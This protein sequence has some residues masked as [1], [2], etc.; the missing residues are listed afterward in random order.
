MTRLKLVERLVFATSILALAIPIGCGSGQLE[1]VY[2]KGVVTLDESPVGGAS[3]MFSPTVG[4]PAVGV[5][6][7]EGEFELRTINPGD[8]AVPGA[9]TVIVTLIETTGVTADADGLSGEVAAGGV[10]TRWVIPE[11]YASPKTSGIEVQVDDSL[12]LPVRI[13]LTSS[14]K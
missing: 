13:S 8:G 4:R 6:N 14:N 12:E 11:K 5:T 10:K 1:T 3:V 9:H 2:V 7:P